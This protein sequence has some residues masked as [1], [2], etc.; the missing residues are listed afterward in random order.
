MH[1]DFYTCSKK[2]F[3]GVG[4]AGVWEADSAPS[5]KLNQDKMEVLL[6]CSPTWIGNGFAASGSAMEERGLQFLDLAVA[7]AGRCWG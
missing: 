4:F 6:T 7:M 1:P 3:F 2:Q 5:G